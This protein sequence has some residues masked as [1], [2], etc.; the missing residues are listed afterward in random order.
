MTGPGMQQGSFEEVNTLGSR[1]SLEIDCPVAWP[2]RDK[3]A[4]TCKHGVIFSISR[5]RESKDW[6]W[7]RRMHMEVEKSI[8]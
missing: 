2:R 3:N 4:L 6:S 5:L 1:L 7:A 8:A